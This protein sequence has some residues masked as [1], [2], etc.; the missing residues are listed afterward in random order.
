MCIGTRMHIQTSNGISKY[1]N[2]EMV[3]T[4]EIER[5]I[6]GVHIEKNI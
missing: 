2:K 5:G 1:E 6:N 3:C 4:P